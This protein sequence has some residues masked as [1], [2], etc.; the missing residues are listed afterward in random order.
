MTN[1]LLEKGANPNI[2]NEQNETPLLTASY[3]GRIE[4]AR[5]LISAGARTDTAES[6]Y[7]MTPLIAAAWK[8]HLELVKLL[9]E[10][11]ASLSSQTVDG[12]TALDEARLRN[13][14]ALMSLLEGAARSRQ[15]K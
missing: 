4:N 5:L 13:D 2:A 10:S 14:V 11:G 12:K 8:G 15:P 7:K 3:R 1:L 6:R 9:L